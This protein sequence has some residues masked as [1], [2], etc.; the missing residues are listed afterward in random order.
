ML[1]Y[2]PAPEALRRSTLWST[3]QALGRRALSMTGA[4]FQQLAD[5]NRHRLLVA[6]A[7]LLAIWLW[8]CG[9]RCLTGRSKILF[10]ELLRTP[11]GN[12][13]VQLKLYQNR[14]ADPEGRE[15]DCIVHH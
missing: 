14:E 5:L 12:R 7:I 1:H 11:V 15:N 9:G 10:K 6:D 2:A 13:A 4:L 3:V 8:V